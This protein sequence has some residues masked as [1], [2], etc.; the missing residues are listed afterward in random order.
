MNN[1]EIEFLLRRARPP[2][3]PAGLRHRILQAA[4]QNAKPASRATQLAGA[5]LAVCWTLIALLQLTTPEVPTGN[6]PFD[7]EAFLARTAALECIVATGQ[8]PEVIEHSPIQE[9]TRIEFFFR[10]P[11]ATPQT[12]EP[13]S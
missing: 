7:R 12:S 8:L 3:P 6:M 9:P 10:L 5:S 1:E 13:A 11:S 2:R 4:Q